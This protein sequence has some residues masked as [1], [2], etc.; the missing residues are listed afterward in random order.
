MK[1]PVGM[2]LL[3]LLAVTGAVYIA[4]T[5]ASPSFAGSVF[6]NF[7]PGDSFNL[8]D[9]PT[10]AE[11]GHTY[12]PEY[13]SMGNQFIPT[14]TGKLLRVDAALRWTFGPTASATGQ[15]VTD[16]G[17]NGP[18]GT[19]LETLTFINLP[20][21]SDAPTGAF[22]ALSIHQPTLVAGTKYWLLITPVDTQS[23]E[24]WFTTSLTDPANMNINLAWRTSTPTSL[25]NWWTGTGRAQAFRIEETPEPATI[26]L[27]ATGLIGVAGVARRRRRK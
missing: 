20:D 21:L 4:L 10:N 19:V 7:G 13:Q 11:I 16:N 6:D 1:T 2:R 3:G 15:V 9:S 26:M 24:L 8:T 27:L 22:S 23:T 25:N 17:N 5:S 18:G 12:Y 14:G